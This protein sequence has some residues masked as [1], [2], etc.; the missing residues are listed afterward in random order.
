VPL[1]CEDECL[2]DLLDVH[3][4]NCVLGVFGDDREEVGEQLALSRVQLL[5]A[6][7]E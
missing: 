1:A 4:R 5:I 3:W 2:A 6:I 7:G